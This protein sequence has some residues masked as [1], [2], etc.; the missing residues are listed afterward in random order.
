MARRF[1][2]SLVVLG[3]LALLA[4]SCSGDGAD[5]V[6]SPTSSPAAST[7]AGPAVVTIAAPEDGATVASPVQVQLEVAG[8]ELGGGGAG[9][10]HLHVMVDVGC[11]QLD[12]EIPSND[13]HVHLDGGETVAELELPPGQHHL[14]AQIGDSAHIAFGQVDFITVAVEGGATPTG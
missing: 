10:P 8:V 1:G 3:G 2:R 14:C 7:P 11:V 5:G 9:G 4:S 12:R 6:A 13:N